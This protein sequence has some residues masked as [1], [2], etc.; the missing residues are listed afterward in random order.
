MDFFKKLPN[1]LKLHIFSFLKTKDAVAVTTTN[2]I[3]RQLFTSNELWWQRLRLD[4]FAQAAAQQDPKELYISLNQQWRN[5]K[6]LAA[7]M[8]W[9]EGE[10][11]Y[12][13]LQQGSPFYDEIQDTVEFI[14]R[15]FIMLP[16]TEFMVIAEEMLSKYN[17]NLLVKDIDTYQDEVEL[18]DEKWLT[19]LKRLNAVETDNAV[20]EIATG[21]HR[22]VTSKCWLH[23]GVWLRMLPSG[24]FNHSE[25]RRHHAAY[26]KEAVRLASHEGVELLLAHGLDANLQGDGMQARPMELVIDDLC[27]LMSV[28][29]NLIEDAT[30]D[31]DIR[32]GNEGELREYFYSRIEIYKS[33]INTLLAH[34]ADVDLL[35][36]MDLFRGESVRSC[37]QISIDQIAFVVMPEKERNMIIGLLRL[38]ADAPAVDAEPEVKRLKM[39]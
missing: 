21:L 31:D 29:E 27:R 32:F 34:G 4:F 16:V 17:N 15:K 5:E 14:R 6:S 35:A 36:K 18:D 33:I 7:F 20:R 13:H 22:C 2:R 9:V 3:N 25:F 8:M 30:L 19:L 37:M 23:L 10:M 28:L 24:M 11:G 38:I 26:F 12:T 1:D 39:G